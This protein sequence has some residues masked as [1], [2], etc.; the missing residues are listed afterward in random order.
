MSLKS[1]RKV[2]ANE[3]GD[4]VLVWGTFM[5]ILF[6]MF[7]ALVLETG[8]LLVRKH[9]VQAAADASALAGAT[10]AQAIV[11]FDSVTKIPAPIDGKT[12]YT[13]INTDD[14]GGGEARIYAQDI[15]DY[16][17][18][19]MNFSGKGIVLDNVTINGTP[20]NSFETSA[21]TPVNITDINGTVKTYYRNYIV[22][23]N[24]YMNAPL[25]GAFFGNDKTYFSIPAGASPK[26]ITS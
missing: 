7:A 14:T 18:S 1:L 16:N 10:A 2:L 21:S 15:L 11:N 6:S 5:L 25:W 3:R 24:G 9:Y 8:D 20:R 26:D 23:L 19:L 17:K 22:V 4:V 12:E 13:I